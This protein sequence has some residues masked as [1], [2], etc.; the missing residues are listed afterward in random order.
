MNKKLI[1]L[2]GVLSLVFISC[3]NKK[4]ET[5]EINKVDEHQ[6]EASQKLNVEVD[7][8]IDPIC[9]M[10]T[11]EYLSDTLHYN[12]KVIGFCSKGCK[13]MFAENPGKYDVK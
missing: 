7:N 5:I 6:M 2:V 3:D 11:A 12:G 8:K 9:E 13:E 10:V 4:E 1:A